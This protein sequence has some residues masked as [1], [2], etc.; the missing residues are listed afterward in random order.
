MTGGKVSTPLKRIHEHAIKAPSV[1]PLRPRRH[2]TPAEVLAQPFILL[3]DFEILGL[4]K[5]ANST[6][7]RWE[8]LGRF[9]LRVKFSA[10]VCA[11][12]TSDIVAWMTERERAAAVEGA[13][14]RERILRQEATRVR[15]RR[16]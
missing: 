4:P 6:R 16:K 13:E 8:A 1:Q 14:Q 3:R 11:Y 2:A 9:P 10:R 12:R 5:F 7:L 15:N